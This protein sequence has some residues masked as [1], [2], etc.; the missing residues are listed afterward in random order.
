MKRFWRVVREPSVPAG[1]GKLATLGCFFIDGA[2]RWFSLEDEIREVPGVPVELWKVQD[3]TAIP[4]GLYR[5]K[6]TYSPHFRRW[7]P[8]L[9]A[10]P[11]F[12]D[13]R[14]HSGNW[15]K[16]TRG[17]I[18]VGFQRAASSIVDS[19]PAESAMVEA[20]RQ[21]EEAGDEVWISVENPPAFVVT[22][23]E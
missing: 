4:A 13:I 17:C 9:F 5:I 22:V 16:N 20:L 6:L 10:V 14:A 23:P 19:K 21:A 15:I 18:L 2:F 11:G 8:E 7:L 3:E 12:T 1:D